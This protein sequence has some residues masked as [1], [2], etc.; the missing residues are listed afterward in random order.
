MSKKSAPVISNVSVTP[1]SGPGGTIFTASVTASGFPSLRITYQWRLDGVAIPG[2][3]GSS[4]IA[5][6]AGAL[7]VLVTATN[8][9]GSDTRE[10]APVT[11]SP[12]LA[13]PA[14]TEARISPVTGAVEDVFTAVA[15]ATGV[16]APTLSYQWAL[17]GIA[18]GGATEANYIAVARGKL[19]VRIT[20]RNSEGADSIE[21]DPVAVETAATAPAIGALRIAPEAGR[22]GET[23]SAIV[24]ASGTPSPALG[25]QW[26]LDGVAIEGA[27]A[28]DF[29]AAAEGALSVRVTATNGAGT[30]SRISVAVPVSA[31]LVA[32][33]I[34]VAT[35]SPA[36]GRVG[37][38]FSVAAS[39]TGEPAPDLSYQWRIEGIEIGGAT[40]SS[41]VPALQGSLSVQVTASNAAGSDTLATAPVT[42]AAALSAP[43]IANITIAPSTGRVGEAFTGVAEVMGE[44]APEVGF[45]WLLDGIAL[46]GA[47]GPSFVPATAGAL[48]LRVSARNSQGVDLRESAPVLLEPGLEAPR[49]TAAAISPE[50]GRV[51]DTFTVTAN[52]TGEPAP[53]VAYQ[54]LLNGESIAGATGTQLVPAAEGNLSVRVTAGNV[55]GTDSRETA[56]VFVG[57]VLTAPAITGLSVTPESGRVGDR[58]AVTVE[59]AGDPSPVLSYQWLLDGATVERATEPA[60]VPAAAGA[61]SVLV[62]ASNTEGADS[63]LSTPVLVE[64]ALAAPKVKSADILPSIGR[65]GDTFTIVSTAIGNPTPELRYV[66]V[67]EDQVIEG[68]NGISFTATEAGTLF[69]RVIATNSE[70]EDIRE[71]GAVEVE[72]ALVAPSITE[73]TIQPSSG[74]VGETF[75][76]TAAASGNPAPLLVYQW[77]MDGAAVEGAQAATF[78]P[79]VAGALSVRVSATNTEGSDTRETPAITVAA[80]LSAPGISEARIEPAQ[81]RV[82]DAFTAT[83]AVTGNPDPVLSYQ[84]TLDGAPITGATNPRFTADATGA[85][86]LRIT[87]RSSEGEATA[88]AGPVTVLAALAPPVLTSATI[89]PTSG[90]VG[91][92]FTATA[93]ASGNPSPIFGYQWLLGGIAIA[94]ATAPTYGATAAGTLTVRVTAGN[95]LGTDSLESAG[96][97]ITSVSSPTVFETGVYEGGVFA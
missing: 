34:T 8:N 23:F 69:V 13:A 60:F 27:T 41:F 49:L 51:G 55:A 87:A 6:A 91:T 79:N 64:P 12:A 3:T 72:P 77:M 38:T 45:Q 50:A 89:S 59:A 11:V 24:E 86:G 17:D 95:S 94:G 25:Y 84:W 76:A 43:M 40:G 21:S 14:I 52:A 22:V 96:A 47:I 30:D 63:V 37:D 7:T 83:V 62:T 5:S 74:R 33:Q 39:A 2:A 73:A 82:G 56:A 80:A 18:I 48:S 19:S 15:E 78:V 67:L 4:L 68:A 85:L 10:S 36:F 97:T 44:P 75:V 66:W 54:W 29:S 71:S 58:F 9:Q 81:G 70:G 31:A 90:P 53:V 61:L 57:N 35:I 42:V 20:A 28:A 1:A 93:T 26:M 65:V 16:P 32:P 92:T 46:E 88:Q